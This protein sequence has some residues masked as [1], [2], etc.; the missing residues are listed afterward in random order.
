MH[1]T[2]TG[3][4]PPPH[5]MLHVATTPAPSSAV[6]M[7]EVIHTHRHQAH[8]LPSPQWLDAGYVTA[9]VLVSSQQRFGV[10]VI[11]PV[12]PDV[13][14]QAH[15]DQGVDASQFAIDWA[16][17]QATC[18]QGHTS[19]SWTPTIDRRTHEVL[20]MRF[21]TRDCQACPLVRRCT[22]ST[23]RAPRRLLSIRP[24]AHYEALRAARSRQATKAF[25]LHDALRS[26]IEA[27]LSQGVRAFGVR[28]S[29]DSG[30][31]K[32]HLQHVGT[33]A[34]ITLVRISAWFDGDELAPT[35]ISA[36]Q[37]LYTA[38]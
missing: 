19:V 5:V 14:W 6:Q 34:A 30:L 15:T 8:L 2:E 27:T 16:R 1:L 11:S 7:S 35:R 28:R 24:Q 4:S 12:H 9:D 21:S 20:K 33:A 18:P 10:A 22:S 32:T 3:E 23:A 29:R 38:A 37:R 17:K 13:Q 26:G 36:F 31:A 25:S